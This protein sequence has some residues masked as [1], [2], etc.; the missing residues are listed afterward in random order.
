MSWNNQSKTPIVD[1]FLL[2]EDS[3]FLLLENGFIILISEGWQKDAKVTSSWTN[4]SK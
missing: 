2:K 1:S 3:D 4:Q